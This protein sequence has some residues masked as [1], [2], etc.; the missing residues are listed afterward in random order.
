MFNSTVLEVAIG[1]VFCYA[2][3]SL[4]VSSVNEAIASALKLRSKL[5]LTG[6]KDILND[7]QFEHLARDIYN[8]A[9]VN[10]ADSGT[11]QKE[12]DLKYKPSAFSANL[13]HPRVLYRG[14][15]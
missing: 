3:V 4:I 15:F 5:L 14:A 1:L 12:G 10:P 8:H 6:I 11:A 2:S 13:L 7:P 9:L